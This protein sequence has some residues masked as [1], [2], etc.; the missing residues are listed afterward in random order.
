MKALYV[1]CADTQR[2]SDEGTEVNQEQMDLMAVFLPSAKRVARAL[3][4]PSIP[5][6]DVHQEAIR[7]L[8]APPCRQAVALWKSSSSKSS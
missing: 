4:A 2:D 7:R 1:K 5:S 8:V 6:Q 3:A